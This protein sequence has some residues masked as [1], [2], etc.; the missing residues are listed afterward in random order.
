MKIEQ[1]KFTKSKGWEISL[2]KENFDASL[3]NL[4]IAFGSTEIVNDPALYKNIK[5]DYP[6]AD[7]N[8]FYSR[9]NLRYTGK[10]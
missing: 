5:A 3:C 6:N 10:R 2:H 4:V 1:K 8:E 7:V 9:G